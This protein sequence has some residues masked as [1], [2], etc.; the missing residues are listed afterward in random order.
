M[1]PLAAAI[2]PRMAASSY[3]ASAISNSVSPDS[4]V[5]I[6]PGA[7]STGADAGASVAV[8]VGAGVDFCEFGDVDVGVDLGGFHA[9]VAQHF[10]HVADVGTAAMHVGGAGVAEEVAGAG[11][12]D[13]AAFEEFFDPV[14]EVVGGV[15]L[16]VAGEKEGGF[17]GQVVEEGTGFG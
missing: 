16:A 12:F 7:P 10:L 4:T 1:R 17:L 6:P 9:F 2:S 11:F 5:Q 13:A 3:T 8:G 15:S 14:A